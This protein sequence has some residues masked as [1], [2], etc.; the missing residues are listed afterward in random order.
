MYYQHRRWVRFSK[1]IRCPRLDVRED[2]GK[3]VNKCMSKGDNIILHKHLNKSS[4]RGPNGNLLKRIYMKEC[5]ADKY[6][7]S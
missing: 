6:M 5:L 7:S 3:A 2:L 1:E 4:R